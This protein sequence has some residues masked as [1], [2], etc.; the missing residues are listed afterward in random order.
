MS[1]QASLSEGKHMSPKFLQFLNCVVNLQEIQDSALNSAGKARK[2]SSLHV[3]VQAPHICALILLPPLPADSSTAVACHGNSYVAVDLFAA[4]AVRDT[5]VTHLS[6]CSV[7][8][9][10]VYFTACA[11]LVPTP[12]SQVP[13]PLYFLLNVF[14]APSP[15]Q[16]T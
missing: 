16:V 1:G 10:P 15:V 4:A 5:Q 13:I 3:S 2:Q 8:L 6:V 14:H 7:Y 9:L 12:N 11:F